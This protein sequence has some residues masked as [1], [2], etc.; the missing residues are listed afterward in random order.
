MSESDPYNVEP[1][2]LS[3]AIEQCEADIEREI[4]K[5]TLPQRIAVTRALDHLVADV[6]NRLAEESPP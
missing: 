2:V 6:A 1:H 3:R 5:F 4:G